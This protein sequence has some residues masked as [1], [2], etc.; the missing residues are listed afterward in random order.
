V[1]SLQLAL[2]LLASALPADA[3]HATPVIADDP[4][5]PSRLVGTWFQR[6]TIDSIFY[7]EMTLF[8]DGTYCEYSLST[9]SDA[10]FNQT[11]GRWRFDQGYLSYQG[12]RSTNPN[13]LDAP[14]G[15][16]VSAMLGPVQSVTHSRLRLGSMSAHIP[17]VY[18]RREPMRGPGVCRTANASTGAK[19]AS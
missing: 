17:S 6:E 16:G 18:R 11:V 3:G 5:H 8:A 9:D 10:P 13:E 2:L 12:E 19:P 1:V 7:L 15:G 14:V 4:E